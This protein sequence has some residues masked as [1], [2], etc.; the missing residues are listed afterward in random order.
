MFLVDEPSPAQVARFREDGFL[1]VERLIAPEAAV[2]LAREYHL[3]RGG[4][5]PTLARCR[6]PS[7]TRERRPRRER[8]S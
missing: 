2:H 7:G 3:G 8:H 1:V 6:G 5:A 4:S